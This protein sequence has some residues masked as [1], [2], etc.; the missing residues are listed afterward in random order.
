MQIGFNNPPLEQIKS[1]LQQIKHIAVVGLS[2]KTSRPS[3]QVAKAMQGYGYHIIPVRPAVDEV[4]GEMA[5]ASLEEVPEPVDLVD[6]FRAPEHLAP[7]IDACIARGVKAVWLQ[8]GV[9]NEK[10]AQRARAAGIMVIMDRCIYRD[11]I[12]LIARSRHKH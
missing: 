12:Q 11:Y 8:D 3:H 5:Y 2:P 10:E 7:I 1:L 6:V 9:I 4:L